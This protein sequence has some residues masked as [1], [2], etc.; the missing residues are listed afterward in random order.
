[1]GLAQMC[2]VHLPRWLNA[3]LYLMAE[4]AV[5]TKTIPA[6]ISANLSDQDYRYRHFSG[7]AAANPFYNLYTRALRES[8]RVF[9]PLSSQPKFSTDA[10]P[11][12]WHSDCPQCSHSTDTPSCWL[13]HL[14]SRRFPDPPVLPS[15]WNH[16][17]CSGIRVICC[18]FSS[19]RCY[20]FLYSTFSYQER[21]RG[22]DL[23]GLPPFICHR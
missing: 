21:L 16:E 8:W 20:L 9:E 2:R 15:K 6:M 22:G 13:C 14:R 4:G 11:G 3:F 23:P 10:N 18:G 7:T 17:G 1:M 5:R 19:R 12:Y